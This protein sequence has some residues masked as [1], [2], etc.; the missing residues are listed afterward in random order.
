MRSTKLTIVRAPSRVEI[1]LGTAPKQ[2]RIEPGKI[3]TLAPF[4][5]LWMRGAKTA[6]VKYIEC[7][8]ASQDW[9]LISVAP[10]VNGREVKGKFL[11]TVDQ[12][13]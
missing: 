7:D 12:F 8:R 10:I 3:Y 4:S 5:D 9:T 6:R 2:L 1:E 11:I 13:E